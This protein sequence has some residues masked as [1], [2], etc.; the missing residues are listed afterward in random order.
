PKRIQW[1]LGKEIPKDRINSIL[2]S[3]NFKLSDKN[4]QDFEVEVPTFRPDVTR[5][6][7]LIEEVA[8]VYGYDNIEPDT[9]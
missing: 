4:G 9:S 2:T 1:L 5:E 7:D 3:L 6:A 8:R